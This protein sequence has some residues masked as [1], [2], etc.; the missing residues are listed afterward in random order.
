MGI[1]NKKTVAFVIPF[2]SSGKDEYN[3]RGYLSQL[4]DVVEDHSGLIVS[5]V[6]GA[7]ETI[8]E[9]KSRADKIYSFINKD[10]VDGVMVA[11]G[12]LSI[13]VDESKIKKFCES[14]YPLPV[15]S[16]SMVIDGIPSVIVD[17]AGGMIASIE[18]LINIHHRRKIAF[19]GG[20][21]SHQEF[22]RRYEVYLEV[23]KKHNLEFDE[24]IVF[25]GNLSRS[26]GFRA[27]DQ[28]ITG[29]HHYDAV[30][31][32]DDMVSLG[33]LDRL[34]A[35][36]IDVPKS[37]SI[38]GFDDEI[39]LV[40]LSTPPM[41]TVKYPYKDLYKIA[42]EIIFNMIEKKDVP[43]ITNV[44]C[45]LVIRES[46][47]CPNPI[48]K[49]AMV[50]DS[51]SIIDSDCTQQMIYK[52]IYDGVLD[53][54]GI[55]YT[56]LMK[57]DL[58][59]VIGAFCTEMKGGGEKGSFAAVYTRIMAK[60]LRKSQ[61]IAP[62]QNIIS[63]I[64][65]HSLSY[66]SSRADIIRAESMLHQV[67]IITDELVGNTLVMRRL[68]VEKTITDLHLM[69]QQMM[70]TYDLPVLLD[71]IYESFPGFGVTKFFLSLYEG[72]KGVSDI[73]RCVLAFDE[74][75]RKDVGDGLLFRTHELIPDQCRSDPAPVSLVIEALFFDEIDIGFFVFEVMPQLEVFY[76]TVS[77]QLSSA[78][79]GGI[80]INERKK[81][82]KK[83][84]EV[85][86]DLENSNN[87][88]QIMSLTDSLTGLY[89]RRGFLMFGD[90][91]V[92]L[93]LRDN[94]DF[95][96]LFADLD[97][98]KRI[99]D[100]YGHNEGDV[101]IIA[102]AEILK[103]TFRESDIVA[104][105][106]GDEFTVLTMN[107]ETG[108]AHEIESRLFRKVNAYNQQ[109]PHKYALSMS[110]GMV[111]FKENPASSFSEL[112]EK[113]D[114]ILYQNKKTKKKQNA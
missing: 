12:A 35:E 3:D 95:L 85:L 105:L 102:A 76:E 92:K 2:L 39:K 7:L 75:G 78:L 86:S 37:V 32:I 62:W 44:P 83:L 21:L 94:K 45:N 91:Q 9:Y 108:S 54:E 80:I 47:G 24:N 59:T 64:H 30:V 50:A 71:R 72:G 1:F 97:G 4:M 13:Y 5:F 6:G 67:R 60:N 49:T 65:R 42:T 89:N 48:L 88:L 58:K 63:V 25:F 112:M 87:K 84:I 111:S 16:V 61:R 99:N 56:G 15:V 17:D 18:H 55:N 96:V 33:V 110:I 68:A 90:Q 36:G 46:C 73:S 106:G 29:K 11:A 104:R 10:T 20:P 74:M 103:E 93:C 57:N 69:G 8:N 28:L 79:M 53:I 34:T 27:A 109:N 31:T 14:F 51:I 107:T 66:L 41:T 101:A 38:V 100:L 98:L 22:N 26:F 19:V 70:T 23:L 77:V 82:E 114:R 52:D 43:M 40:S 81:A 113:A